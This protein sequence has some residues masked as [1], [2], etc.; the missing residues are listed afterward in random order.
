MNILL[1]GASGFLGR[2]LAAALLAAGHQVIPVSRTHGI[3]FKQQLSPESWLPL[4]EEIDAV[5]NC[6]GII[7]ERGTQRFQALHS[8]A[9]IALFQACAIAGIKRVIQISALGADE[10][11]FSRYHLSKLAADNALRR[12]D[13]DW[14]VLR[15]AIVIGQGGAS[16]QWLRRMAVLPVIPVIGE[17]QQRLQLVLLQEVVTTVLTCLN[18]GASKQTLDVVGPETLIVA[19]WLQAMRCAQGLG[20]GKLWHCPPAL[21]MGLARLGRLISPMLSPDSVRMLQAGYHADHR[22]LEQ[23]LGRE[24][25]A[26]SSQ[27][28]DPSLELQENLS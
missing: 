2:N 8:D 21:A 26:V 12:L 6:V 3:D 24:L 25:Q 19:E 14:F 1:T 27:L 16:T 22:P 18:S 17:G 11:A 7:G 13:L 5:I 28:N 9:P 15:P 10:A 4:L 20:R 23:F